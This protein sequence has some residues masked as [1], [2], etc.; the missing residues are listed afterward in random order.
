MGKPILERMRRLSWWKD[1]GL[2]I[3][4]GLGTSVPVMTALAYGAGLNVA[5]S[6]ACGLFTSIAVVFGRELIQNWGDKPEAGAVE[7][8]SFDALFGMLGACLGILSLLWA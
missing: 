8:T 6:A 3:L 2:H 7:D 5:A 4:L 1:Q